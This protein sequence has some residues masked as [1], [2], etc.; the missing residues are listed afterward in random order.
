MG[1]KVRDFLLDNIVM[2]IFIVFVAAG[3][4]VS[5]GL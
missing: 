2:L 5:Q 1:K 4:G 3:I